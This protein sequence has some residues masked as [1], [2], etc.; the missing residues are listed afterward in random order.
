MNT[1]EIIARYYEP[2]SKAFRILKEHGELVAQRALKATMQVEHLQPDL[3]FIESAA[4]LHDIGIFLTD[5]PGLDCHGTEPYV[6][7]GVLGREILDAL[8][9]PR[10]GWVCERH[11]GVGISP[12]DIRA[13][14]LPLPQRDMRPVTLEEQIICYADKFFSKNGRGTWKSLLQRSSSLRPY[15]RTRWSGS[16]GGWTF[17]DRNA[18]HRMAAG[19]WLVSAAT[20][21]EQGMVTT[22]AMT[23]RM[24][25]SHL[26]P[27]SLRVAP[28]PMMPPAM[29]WVVDTGIPK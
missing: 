2:S 6:R 25:M 15:G 18:P 8:G 9:M 4:L 7:H 20:R 1:I 29:V 24:A 16:W 3:T 19:A 27:V 22:H 17:S 28:T 12:E 26:M 10:H 23:M 21:A 11:V 14:N 5:S 13:F